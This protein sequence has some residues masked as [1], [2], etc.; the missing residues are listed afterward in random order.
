MSAVYVNNL[1]INTGTDF[2]QIFTLASSS[3]NSALNLSGF[4]GEAKLGKHPYS[5]NKIGFAV[6]FVVVSEGVIS[7]SLTANQ[8]ATLKEGRYVY[9]VP[10]S[11]QCCE[12]NR[13]Y[14]SELTCPRC[15]SYLNS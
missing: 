14:P 5:T 2:E 11:L 6:S 13:F 4:T 15:P 7:I 12:L 8:T 1:V 9:D 3:G 10:R